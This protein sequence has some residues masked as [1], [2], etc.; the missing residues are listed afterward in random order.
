MSYRQDE[1]KLYHQNTYT[2]ISLKKE[3]NELGLEQTVSLWDGDKINLIPMP[4]SDPD[5]M[6]DVQST[7]FQLTIFRPTQSSYMAQ[8]G[9]IDLDL[10]L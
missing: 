7:L 2:D 6:R 4:S 5:G 3:S 1:D 10:S 9:F 8:S